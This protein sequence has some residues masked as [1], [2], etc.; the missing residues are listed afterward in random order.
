MPTL[1]PDIPRIPGNLHSEQEVLAALRTLPPEAHVFARL[2]ILD[3]GTNR[4]RELDFL[5]IHPDLGLVIVEVKGRGVE[6]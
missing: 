4:D 3:P 6:P 2:A 5:V 1:H